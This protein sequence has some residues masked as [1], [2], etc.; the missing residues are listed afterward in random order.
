M[1]V[2]REVGNSSMGVEGGRGNGIY[3]FSSLNVNL[4]YF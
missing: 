1:Y 4:R 2:L 3:L